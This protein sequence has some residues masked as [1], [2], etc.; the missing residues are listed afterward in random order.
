MYNTSNLL[1]AVD[2]SDGLAHGRD[3]LGVFIG[4]F[5]A[6]FVFEGHDEFDQVER[7]GFELFAETGF[8][9]DLALVHAEQINNDGLDFR[10]SVRQN[11]LL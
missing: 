8:H 1:V 9:R 7:I 11:F 3:F 6:E 2:V 4:D 10:I 5:R